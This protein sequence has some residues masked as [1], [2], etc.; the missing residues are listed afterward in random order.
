MQFVSTVQSQIEHNPLYTIR[1]QSSFMLFKCLKPKIETLHIIYVWR[2]NLKC[3]WRYCVGVCVRVVCL[4]HLHCFHSCDSFDSRSL[5]FA[6][7]KCIEMNE[8]KKNAKRVALQTTF[9]SIESSLLISN[10][11]TLSATN[12]R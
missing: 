7:K 10:S 8:Q 12:N 11:H 3:A 2:S 4:S 1:R 5:S 6:C 9:E